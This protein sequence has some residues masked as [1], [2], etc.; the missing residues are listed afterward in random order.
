M[1]ARSQEQ[2]AS[3]HG[4]YPLVS[5][6]LSRFFQLIAALKRMARRRTS[7]SADRVDRHEEDRYSQLEGPE[8]RSLALEGRSLR[9]PPQHTVIVSGPRSALRFAW[10]YIRLTI[11]RG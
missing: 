11:W 1:E 4:D 6:M 7:L 8:R 9:Y 5:G 3:A 2:S 10:L